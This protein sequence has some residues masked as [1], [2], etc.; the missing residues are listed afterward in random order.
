MGPAAA[1]QRGRVLH[2]LHGPA[3]RA[4]RMAIVSATLI[5]QRRA[6]NQ[7]IEAELE[8]APDRGPASHAVRFIRRRDVQGLHR[9]CDRSDHGPESG[10]YGQSVCSARPTRALSAGIDY[11]IGMADLSVNYSGR[12]HVL[13]H[14]QH[15]QGTFVRPARRTHCIRSRGPCAGPWPWWGKNLTDEL[16]RVNIIPYSGEEISQFGAPRTYGID[17]T[18]RY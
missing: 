8:L 13:G 15:R 5:G 3:G 12:R 6:R 9:I 2:G 4:D 1:H 18:L 10:Q 14:R 16:Y 7:G 11:R 17:L